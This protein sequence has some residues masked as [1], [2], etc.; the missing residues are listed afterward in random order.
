MLSA[1]WPQ[2]IICLAGA[3]NRIPHNPRHTYERDRFGRSSICISEVISF[4]G[5]ISLYTIPRDIVNVQLHRYLIFDPIV[6][7][8]VDAVM[9]GSILETIILDHEEFDR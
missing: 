3:K 1:K 6:R 9:E 7:P 8:Y 5:R 2:K 4:D